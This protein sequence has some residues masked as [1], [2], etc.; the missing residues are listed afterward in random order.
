MS[1]LPVLVQE[2]T[3]KYVCSEYMLT[4]TCYDIGVNFQSVR[5]RVWIFFFPKIHKSKICVLPRGVNCFSLRSLFLKA[6]V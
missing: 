4:S 2:L 6:K 3:D 5:F 1:S